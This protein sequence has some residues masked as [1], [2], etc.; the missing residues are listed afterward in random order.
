MSKNRT[1]GYIILA[2]LAVAFSVI[3]FA[4]PFS[5]T[6]VFWLGYVFAVMAIVYQIYVFKIS[7]SGDVEAKS[8]FYGFPIAKIGVVY[9]IVQLIVSLIEIA[10]AM[11]IPFWIVLIVNVIIVAAAVI[12]CI[13]A[14]VMRDEIVRQDIETEKDVTFMRT[15]QSLSIAIVGLCLDV[16]VKKLAQNIADEIRFSDPVSSDQTKDL[17][18]ELKDRMNEMKKAVIEGDNQSAKDLGNRIIAN[19]AERNRFCALSK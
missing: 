5:K 18:A 2:I 13:A 16:E 9:L 14:D 6:T 8:K 19:L 7:F 10:A 15:L 1:R 12:G 3:A 11:F 4:A 17:E